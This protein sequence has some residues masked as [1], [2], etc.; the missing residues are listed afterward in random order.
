MP[1]STLRIHIQDQDIQ[2]SGKAKVDASELS[3]PGIKD[4]RKEKDKVDIRTGENETVTTRKSAE[5]TFDV[6]KEKAIVEKEERNNV[7]IRELPEKDTV[8]VR[9][10]E[11][12]NLDTKE[13]SKNSNTDIR[14]SEKEVYVAK[15]ETSKMHTKEVLEKHEMVIEESLANNSNNEN[16]T[17]RTSKKENNDIIR[18][19]NNQ[20]NDVIRTSKK[21]NN[22]TTRPSIDQNNDAIRTSKKETNNNIRTSNTDNNDTIGTSS[23]ENN[24]AIRSSKNGNNDARRASN[25]EY[26]DIIR[27]SSKEH[28]DGIRT[29]IIQNNDT[30]RT[31]QKENND[32]IR[33]SSK[34][35]NNTIITRNKQ[36]HTKLKTLNIYNNNTF[37][38]SS[39]ENSN[40]TL[41]SGLK[42]KEDSGS[43]ETE[44]ND[45]F[46]ENTSIKVSHSKSTK[47]QLITWRRLA[48]T[49][50]I[51]YVFIKHTNCSALFHNSSIEQDKMSKR[52]SSLEQ[53]KSISS[54]EQLRKGNVISSAKHQ[55]TS[56]LNSTNSLTKPLDCKTFKKDRKYIMYPTSKEEAGY[57]LAFSIMMYRNPEMVERLLRAIYR[58]QNVYCIHVDLKSNQ[59]ALELMTSLV[60]CFPNVVMAEKL[61]VTW[62]TMS[63]VCINI[64]KEVHFLWRS[65]M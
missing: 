34:E 22:D 35:N 1:M 61:N 51:P 38:I 44:K 4:I 23:K 24:G 47:L 26:N 54:L 33:T 31:R 40:N 29:S 56:R 27:N 25:Q 50:D 55:G 10:E 37:R 43:K 41:D 16:D 13:S 3:Q 32:T 52:K 9:N 5:N 36:D 11:I 6:R 62:G 28:I 2:T 46:A 58:P 57:P 21:D 14:S 8:D 39:K 19:S 64:T 15:E 18:I 59:D 65:L 20:N 48:N 12:E 7:G 63:V 53:K 49:Q 42:Q 30:I 17:I 45:L 60:D